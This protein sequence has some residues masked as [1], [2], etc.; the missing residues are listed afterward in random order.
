MKPYNKSRIVLWFFVLSA[1][2]LLGGGTFEHIVLTPL[3]A[4]SPPGSVTQ[5]PHG[6]V[7][8][9]FFAIFS[10][11]YALFLLILAVVLWWMPRP[12]RKWALVAVV[13]GLVVVVSTFFFFVPILGKT[14]ATAGAGLSADEITRLTNQF[15]N[16]NIGRYVLMISA[17]AAGLR[18]LIVS[19]SMDRSVE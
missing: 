2:F 15:V 5:W 7:Q 18:A 17:W 11:L 16:W 8:A 9:K 10:S 12:Q 3:W 19:Y 4:G 6:T 14:Q 1:T 13:C